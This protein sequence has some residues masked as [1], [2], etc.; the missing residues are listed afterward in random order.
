VTGEPVPPIPAPD[1]SKLADQQKRRLV[2]L[3]GRRETGYVQR[4]LGA[5][6]AAAR[7]PDAP[8]MEPI[9]DA[10][11]ARATLGEISDVLRGV[12]GVYNAR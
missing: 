7:Q 10:V 12:W 2:E 3:R 1:Y 9:L 6:E 11:R 8:L 5:L 4:A